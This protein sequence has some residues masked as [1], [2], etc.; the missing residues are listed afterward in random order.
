MHDVV[1]ASDETP[2]EPQAV[3]TG[4]L[5]VSSSDLLVQTLMA[6]RHKRA[7]AC[8]LVLCHS[9]SLHDGSV[10][11]R[12][13]KKRASSVQASSPHPAHVRTFSMHNDDGAAAALTVQDGL[14]VCVNEV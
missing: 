9:Y 10:Q 3:D 11:A 8:F 4:V 6:T 2:T 12:W 7:T 5:P 1:A 14:R 13:G